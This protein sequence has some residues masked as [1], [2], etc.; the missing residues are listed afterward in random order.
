MLRDLERV[1]GE[2]LIVVVVLEELVG[3]A[4]HPAVDFADYLMLG[5]GITLMA[6]NLPMT[7]LLQV[8]VPGE[9]RGRVMSV[10]FSLV[11]AMGP[12]GPI[13][14]GA[15]ASHSSISFSFLVSGFV[16]SVIMGV[17]FLTMS[18]LRRIHY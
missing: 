8:K 9:L 13:A 16:I 6:T 10:F 4:A 18:T 12:V 2:V 11:V 1:M 3:R 17:G 7:A 15:L 5:L 14:V